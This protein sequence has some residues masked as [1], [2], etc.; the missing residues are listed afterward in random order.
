MVATI[1]LKK[2]ETS[3]TTSARA[4][5]K[6]GL[7]PGVIYGDN[8]K[9]RGILFTPQT[10]LSLKSGGM[11]SSIFDIQIEGEKEPVKAILQSLDKDPVTDVVRHVDLYQVR[12]DRELHTE[13]QIKFFGVS[14]A[15]KDLGGTLVKVIDELPISCLPSDLI[16]HVEV[17]IS[18]LKT[19]ED[20]I[21][22]KDIKLPKG[23][24]TRLGDEEVIAN[25]MKPLTEE[26][27]AKMQ[28]TTTSE[29]VGEVEV[30]GKKKEDEEQEDGA[31][32]DEKNK[33]EKE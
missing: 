7:I 22:V 11:G 28:E 25:V 19:F 5:R 12:A 24:E 23:V 21:L 31:D 3:G 15:V 18:S 27:L 8:I 33:K 29:D 32:S 30:V 2:R 9:S 6:K 20:S 13:I 14:S 10:V 4:L 17:D 1:K 16:H 26:E